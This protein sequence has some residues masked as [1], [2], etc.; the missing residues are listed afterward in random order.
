M[1]TD[2]KLPSLH[3]LGP[4]TAKQLARLHIHTLR[5]LLFHLPMRYQNRAKITPIRELLPDH[6]ATIEGVLTK[7]ETRERGRTKLLCHLQ[8][9]SGVILLRFFHTF[10]FASPM[11]Q[12]GHKWRCYGQVRLGATGLEMMHPTFRVIK[13]GAPPIIESHLT[14]IY[15]TTAGLSQY[16]LQQI[17]KQA[18]LLL[19]KEAC[20]PDYLPSSY[21]QAI[22]LKSALVFL[23]QPPL[24]TDLNDLNER[25]TPAHARLIFEELVAHRLSLLQLK[26]GLH[27]GQASLLAPQAELTTTFIHSLPFTLTLA[28][29]RVWTEIQQDLARKEP[30]LRLLQGDVGSGKTVIAA[31]AA[32]QAVGNGTQVALMA[33]TA[34]LAEQHARVFK[35]WL[36]PLNI[37]VQL[38][39]GHVKGRARHAI[40]QGLMDGQVHI[41]IGTH[42]LFQEHVQ[43]QQLGLVIIDEQ[44]RFGVRARALLRDKGV[45]PHQLVM[46]ATPIPR[47]LAMS[48]YANLDC[49]ILDELPPGRTPIVTSVIAAHKRDAVMQRVHDVCLAGRQAYWVCCLIEE[50]ETLAHEAATDMQSQLQAACPNLRIGLV[51]GRMRAPEKEAVMQAF[52]A[53]ELH[54]LVATTVIEVGVDVPNASIMVIENAERLGLSQLHQ[55]RGRVG[56]GQVASFCVLLYQPPLSPIA[57]SRLEVIRNHTDGFHIAEQDLMLRGPGELLGTQQTGDIPFLFADVIRDKALLPYVTEVADEMRAK[58]PHNVPLLIERWLRYS[59]DYQV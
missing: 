4:Q 26:E 8:D 43:F 13:A 53:N 47:T 27:E 24:T 44:H 12:V 38:L 34:L 9:E 58:H 42:A 33:P 31:L 59:K 19:E 54:V 48:F 16:Q 49:S 46:T 6:E 32:L 57:A 28:Q 55:L 21:L 5:D 52:Q 51:H 1:I 45:Y 18:L 56:R 50:S 20:L 29:Q 37:N 14:P 41:V 35:A 15:P 7:V 22:S 3:G 36:T 39:A 2:N 23:H 40:L 30:M 17:I 25:H 11:K 10:A